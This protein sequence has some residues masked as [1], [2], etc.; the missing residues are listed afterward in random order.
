MKIS[1]I[2]YLAR[3]FARAKFLGQKDPLL[4][5]IKLTHRCTLKCRPC[6]YWH[7]QGPELT[8]EA[9]KTKMLE[10]Y[11]SGVRLLILEG[12]EPLLW[13]DGDHTLKDLVDFGRPLFYTIGATTNGTL[14]LEVPTDVLW[15]SID[16]LEETHD[17]L[18][19]RSFE[20]IIKNIKASSH[21]NIFANITINRLNVREIPELVKYLKGLVRGVTIQFF[22]PYPESENLSL[23]WEERSWVLEELMKLKGEGYPIADSYAALRAL[24]DNSWKCEPWMLANVDPVGRINHGCYLLNRSPE[25]KPCSLCGFAAHTEISLA[26]QFNLEAIFAGRHIL[27]IF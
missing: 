25:D 14:P 26:Y 8:F 6:P 27:R 24:K 15:V 13:R 1:R 10:L 22:F 2:A 12:G 5:G 11:K 20:T 18:R 19:G 16:G 4:G 9:A 7:R 17:Y 21:S 23:S 3:Y